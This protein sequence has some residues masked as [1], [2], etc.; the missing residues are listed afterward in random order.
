MQRQEEVITPFDFMRLDRNLQIMIL[1]YLPLSDFENLENVCTHFEKLCHSPAFWQPKIARDFPSVICDLVNH[2]K[3]ASK[4]VYDLEKAIE[5][6]SSSERYKRIFELI[7]DNNLSGLIAM[8]LTFHDIS[9][10]HTKSDVNPVTYAARLSRF[11]ILNNFYSI[12][13][14]HYRDIVKD[15]NDN[16]LLTWAIRCYQPTKVLQ[17]LMFQYPDWR[18]HR[19]KI[20]I[21]LAEHASQVNNVSALKFAL[22]Q[23]FPINSREGS[24]NVSLLYTPCQEGFLDCVELLVDRGIDINVASSDDNSTPLLA[25]VEYGHIDC[26]KYLLDH[27][28]NATICRTKGTERGYYGSPLFTA[29]NFGYKDLVE[30]LLN[31]QPDFDARGGDNQD[32]IC[33]TPEGIAFKK[34]YVEIEKL[35][36]EARR[37]VASAKAGLR[38]T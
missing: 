34:G 22:D 27:G 13:E 16:I 20:N 7:R 4:K 25:A 26:V 5:F 15:R 33:Y 24:C 32:C 28:A 14:L 37:A 11:N 31:Y 23:G 30:L 36:V 3:T 10:F 21:S 8:Q 6:K 2:H 17:A 9:C 1:N 19:N 12:A 35:L 18:F 29:A 38:L